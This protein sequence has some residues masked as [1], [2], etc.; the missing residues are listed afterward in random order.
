MPVVLGQRVKASE[1][2]V[3]LDA[4]EITARLDQA[5][6]SLQQA[7]RDGKRVAS[8]FEQQAVTRAE[9]DASEVRHRVALGGAAEAKAMMSYVEI[10]APFDGVVARKWAEVGDLALPGKPLISIEDPS[11]LQL[12]ADVPQGIL[13]HIQQDAR[14]AARVDGVSGEVTG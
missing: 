6:A 13:S 3:R 10:L 5:V 7:E 9:Y 1:R 11:A 14:L 12:E 4:A 8:L 2:L